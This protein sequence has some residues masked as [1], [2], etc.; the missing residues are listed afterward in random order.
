[1][2]QAGEL[3][4]D[5]KSLQTQIEALRKEA[6]ELLTG[7]SEAQ[8]NWRPAPNRWSIGECLEHLN[9]TA[10]LY[11]PLLAA[12]INHARATGGMS[13]GPYKHGWLGNFLV[14]SAEPPPKMRFPAPRRFRPQTNLPLSQVVS[15]FDTFQERLLDLMR[16]ANG[17]DLGRTKVQM[18]ATKLIQLTLGQ[19][20]GLVAAHQRRHL[21]QARQVREEPGFPK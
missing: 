12:A 17:V 15:Q 11:W 8:F 10:R 14:R 19:A 18:P 20:F 7:M 16:D 9:V 4:A 13:P 2:A 1:M 3:H 6:D 21:W 5:L